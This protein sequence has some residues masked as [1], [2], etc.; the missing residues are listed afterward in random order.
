MHFVKLL[1]F[2]FAILS[3]DVVS[4]DFQPVTVVLPITK[5]TKTSLY[6]VV[7][8]IWSLTTNS[9]Y[10]LDLD[11]PFIWKQCINM[12]IHKPYKY[13]QDQYDCYDGL[14]C[15]SSSCIDAKSYEISPNCP[16]LNNITAKYG[17]ICPVTPVNPVTKVCK[18]SQLTT[19]ELILPLTDGRNPTLSQ[20]SNW[21][22]L[23][24]CAPSSLLRSMP[25]GVTGVAA[26]SWSNLAFPRQLTYPKPT[27]QFALCLPTSASA[28]GVTFI[29]DGP[30]Y[31]LPFP[32]LD[33]KSILSYT[34]MI[35]KSSK[36]LGYYVTINKISI[37]RKPIPLF[38]NISAKLSTLVPYTTLRSDIYAALLKSFSMSIKNIHRVNTTKP[39]GL[40]MKASDIASRS[41][42]FSV[43]NID[44]EMESGKIW[45]I[46]KDNSIKEMGN[47]VACLAFVDGGLHVDDAIVIGTFQMENNFLFFDLANQKFWFSSSLLARGTSCS[48]FNTTVIG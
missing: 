6:K 13:C 12:P 37:K 29:G 26:F 22:Y 43:P 1:L 4:I 20:L 45:T 46:S 32:N 15:K 2:I 5:D 24:S 18:I 34:P 14:Y 38:K 30:F 19:K 11:A 33:I 17:C 42:K 28:P 25:K 21:Y 35:R 36:S 48:S 23:F 7:L 40:C 10:L 16:S 3:H 27:Q 41:S 9:T 39:F 8:T 47:G 44:L 31:F